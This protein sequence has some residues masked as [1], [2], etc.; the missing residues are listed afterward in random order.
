MPRPR[1][2][3]CRAIGRAAAG[4]DADELV[5]TDRMRTPRFAGNDL[6]E[7]FYQGITGTFARGVR[8]CEKARVPSRR[9]VSLLSSR[10]VAQRA[11]SMKSSSTHAVVV[12]RGGRFDLGPLLHFAGSRTRR[13]L[14][15]GRPRR[16]GR[17][18]RARNRRLARLQE[19]ATL[20]QVGAEAGRGVAAEVGRS[21]APGAGEVYFSR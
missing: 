14:P 18:A 2:P 17:G 10:P 7:V 3:H 16:W 20:A 15:D 11:A 13:C 4:L 9:V 19:A 12:D 8:A 6:F 5:A 1:F 21:E